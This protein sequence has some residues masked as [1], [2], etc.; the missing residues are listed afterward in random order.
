MKPDYPARASAL[1]AAVLFPPAMALLAAML[2]IAALGEHPF[3]ALQTIFAG[4]FGSAESLG[5]TLY[6]AT[7]FIFAGLAVSIP[8]RA[9]LFNIGV[10]G[11]ATVSGIGVALAALNGGALAPIMMLPLVVAAGVAFGAAWAFLPAWLQVRRGSHIVITTIL[12]NFI[13]SALL[14]YL[15]VETLRAPGSMQPETQAFPPQAL[16]PRASDWL[17][18]GGAPL[19]AS[20]ALALLAALAAHVFI[21]RTRAGYELRVAGANPNAAD[22]A[23]ISRMRTTLLAMGAAGALASGIALNELCG[24]QGRLILEF[25]GGYGFV[26]IAVALV[27]RSHAGGIVLAAILFGALYQGGAELAFDRPRISRDL[28]VL[29]QGVVV[30]MVGCFSG[31]RLRLAAAKAA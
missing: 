22:Y 10:E 27:G 3:T 16:L 12:L 13:A 24:A 19:N 17:P 5:F 4:A 8:F 20:F 15:L 31:R 30:L 26:G 29:V 7:N 21:T 23:G 6:Y 14:A 18:V 25:T 11:Q 28:I 2:I 9:G 1:L